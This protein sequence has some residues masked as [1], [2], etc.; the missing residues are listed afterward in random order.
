MAQ[1][2]SLLLT[3]GFHFTRRR[4]PGATLWVD[5]QD[6][7]WDIASR[8][9]T[10]K[11]YNAHKRRPHRNTWRHRHTGFGSWHWNSMTGHQLGSPDLRPFDPDEVWRRRWWPRDHCTCRNVFQ[12]SSSN[13]Q[14]QAP[15]TS[16]TKIPPPAPQTS[17]CGGAKMESDHS[18]WSMWRVMSTFRD[19][20]WRGWGLLVWWLVAWW[21][22]FGYGGGRCSAQPHS[23][24]HPTVLCVSSSPASLLLYP[25]P[26]FSPSLW[27]HAFIS[28]PSLP[29]FKVCMMVP[30]K[31]SLSSSLPH[32]PPL[33]G[34]PFHLHA[35]RDQ[36]SA[37]LFLSLWRCCYA[38]TITNSHPHIRSYIL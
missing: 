20:T 24:H 36:G 18:L 23:R 34:S 2:L 1:H 3:L 4:V 33:P 37:L 31:G 5:P 13:S 9:G 30:V 17:C 21:R 10:T 12:C 16:T 29:S 11:Q 7:C 35:K 15:K 22:G 28:L 26:S 19:S 8:D 27:S 14:H 32:C 38:I 6:S 25:L